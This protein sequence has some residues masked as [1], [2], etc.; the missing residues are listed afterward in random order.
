MDFE[1]NK[2]RR[3]CPNKSQIER[4]ITAKVSEYRAQILELKAE[5]KEFTAVSLMEKV[6]SPVKSKTVGD[7]FIAQINS[8][9]EQKRTGYA[10]SHLEVYNSLVISI[11]KLYV[12]I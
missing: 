10:M 5:N 7:L 6:K 3:N 8:L 2:P 1:K 12:S 9:K 11:K 4:V